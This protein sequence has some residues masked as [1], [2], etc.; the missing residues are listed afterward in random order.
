MEVYPENEFFIILMTPH[1]CGM[2]VSLGRTNELP[3]SVVKFVSWLANEAVS[4]NKPL[5]N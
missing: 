4:Y 2:V 5:I 1:R 3:S